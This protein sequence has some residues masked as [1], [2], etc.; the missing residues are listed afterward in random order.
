MMI[1]YENLDDAGF[2][3]Q[4]LVKFPEA[5]EHFDKWFEE[6]KTAQNWKVLFN[7]EGHAPR[8]PDLP[9]EMQQGILMRYEIEIASK[10]NDPKKEISYM[11]HMKKYK[12]QVGILFSSI[13]VVLKKEKK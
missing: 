5:V 13:H 7:S 10:Y 6:Y 1:V 11:A 9:V 4:L 8:F 12:N 3:N 2:W